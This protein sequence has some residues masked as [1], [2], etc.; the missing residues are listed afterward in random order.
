MSPGRR[1]Q[2]Y[3]QELCAAI[4]GLDLNASGALQ[5][6]WTGPLGARDPD[7]EN[8]LVWDVGSALG[9]AGVISFLRFERR[10]GP[11]PQPLHVLGFDAQHH[12]AV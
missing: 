9:K 2:P 12:S 11:L 10:N 5:A 1:R 4:R 7:V 6:T 8:L 3:H